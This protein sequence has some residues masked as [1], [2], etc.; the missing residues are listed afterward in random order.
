MKPSRLER[1]PSVSNLS[2]LLVLSWGMTAISPVQGQT[3]KE[4]DQDGTTPY[5]IRNQVRLTLAG[6]KHALA[7]SEKKAK[8]MGLKVNIAVVDEG[9]HLFSFARMDGARTASVATALTKATTAATARMATGP[10]PSKLGEADILLNLSVQNAAIASDG[11]FTTLYGGIPIIVDGQVI[12][13]VGVGGASGE[14]DAEVAKA[15]V[16]ALMGTIGSATK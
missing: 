3:L 10:L 9:G 7:A 11:K 5:V 13:A 2:F 6:A 16:A 1:S 15:G 8:E 4:S 12:G 14:Q